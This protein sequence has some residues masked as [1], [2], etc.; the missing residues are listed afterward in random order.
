MKSNNGVVKKVKMRV[1]L[2]SSVFGSLIPP[3]AW[4]LLPVCSLQGIMV[5]VRYNAHAFFSSGTKNG[6][7]SADLIKNDASWNVTDISL[8]MDLWFYE[9]EVTS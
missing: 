5:E 4:K 2:M 7:L 9:P 8:N 3:E 6:M 1:P